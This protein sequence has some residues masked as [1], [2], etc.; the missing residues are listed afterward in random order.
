[1]LSA[2]VIFCLLCV[3]V[4]VF[5]RWL[6]FESPTELKVT[7]NVGRGTVGLAEPDS[8]EKAIRTNA[9]VGRDNRLSTDNTS[10]GYMAFSDPYSGDIL[11]TI[12]L[13][14]NSVATLSTAN[15]PRFSMSD[16]IYVIRVTGASGRFEV[17]VGDDLQRELRLEISGPLG[18]AH[19]ETSGHYL[20]DTTTEYMTLNARLGTATLISRAGPTQHLSMSTEGT[21]RLGENA[22]Q[23]RP[24]PVDLLPNWNFDQSQD[25]PVEWNC[26]HEYSPDNQSGPPGRWYFT[27]V[28]GRG[29]VH[30]ER[31]QPQPGPGTTLCNQ[32]LS[33]PDGQLD[34]S[35]YD[36]LRLRLTMQVHH[37]SLSA[38]GVIGTECPV[39]LHI[40]YEDKNGNRRSWYH[41]FYAEYRPNEGRTACGECLEEH[42]Q[43]N[44]DAW[45]TYESGNLFTDW[46]EDLR[47]ASIEFIEFRAG[48]HQYDVM[49]SEVALIATRDDST[50]AGVPSAAVPIRVR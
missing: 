34:V 22:I 13:R 46:P 49:L 35:Q 36:G 42:E 31:M 45:Y 23:T 48:G 28:D 10:Q 9:T 19:I 17:W 43:I 27:R 18:T 24:G 21:I 25:W 3:S 26:T 44:K 1:M 14:K 11:A 8:D 29:A 4:F 37:Q 12:M 33:G 7:I 50:L 30:I 47:P 2:L 15:R 38:C 32:Y 40:S 6:V 16:N 5:A 41:G 39:M 20:I